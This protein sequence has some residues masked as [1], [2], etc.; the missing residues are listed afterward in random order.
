MK[1]NALGV[2]LFSL[3]VGTSLFISEFFVTL[4]TPVPVYKRPSGLVDKYSC[5]HQNREVLA[6]RGSDSRFAINVSKVIYDQS[7]GKFGLTMLIKSQNREDRSLLVAV[8]FFTVGAL[9][10]KGLSTSK[11]LAT[12]TLFAE[13]EFDLKGNADQEISSSFKWLNDLDR[14]DNLYVIVEPGRMFR[15]NKDREPAFELSKATPVLVEK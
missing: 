8:H 4:P 6:K 11:Y 5:S 14:H 7:T 13:P 10:A 2:M 9:T 1:K 12:E 3:I 15:M